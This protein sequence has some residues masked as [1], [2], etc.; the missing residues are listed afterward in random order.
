MRPTGRRL[1]TH[2][3]H[4]IE[5]TMYNIYKTNYYHKLSQLV[6]KLTAITHFVI[7]CVVLISGF[8]RPLLQSINFIRRINALEYTKL[9]G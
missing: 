8:H 4:E 3:L 5:Q 9:R 2:A 1:E 7:L 6:T